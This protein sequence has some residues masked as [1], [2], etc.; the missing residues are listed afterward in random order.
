MISKFINSRLCFAALALVG[1][2]MQAQEVVEVDSTG[3]AASQQVID[4]VKTFEKFKV[5]GV[6]AQVGKYIVLDSDIDRKY[7]QIEQQGFSTADITRCELLGTLMEE[8][9]YAHHAIQDSVII[10]DA[11]VNATTDQ[12]IQYMLAQFNSEEQV[13]K[14]YK[15]KSMP[16]LRAELFQINKDNML[17]SE[18]QN[19][20]IEGVEITP[21]EVRTFFNSIPV[22]ERP[23]FSAEVEIAQIVIEPEIPQEE[24]QKVIDRLN[25]F[26]RGIVENGESFATKAVLYSQ[27]PG[28]STKGG[29]I[30]LKRSDNFVKEFK[31]V[32]FSLQEGEVSEPF[33]SEFGYH[34]LM[35]DKIRG[36][37]VDVRHI[38]LIPDVTDETVAVAKAKIENIRQRI[39]D[40][41][42]TFA[43]AA[44]SESDEKETKN[45][46]GQLVNP[47]S[48][49][50]RFDLTKM[51]P[52]LAQQIYN[53]KDKEVSQVLTDADRTGRKK[54]KIIMVTDR[55]DEHQADYSKDYE[56]IQDLALN[57]K[58]RR[59]IE[60][61]Q[62]EKILETFVSVNRDYY[63]C[64]F[65]SNWIKN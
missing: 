58:R 10:P 24:I 12:Q 57:D 1:L 27:D 11:Q 35:V 43:E 38:L 45:D 42:L 22:D 61:W 6:S 29:K 49:D 21:E 52:V 7:I 26:R 30:S 46:G 15:K 50:T 31:D 3:V 16:E 17:A 19:K 63:D 23:L 41:E 48:G 65:A 33:E 59:A 55:Y 34:I 5:D 64:D 14:F 60:E 2:Q 54:F 51:E 8:K 4:T 47:V 53:L 37:T 32:A 39:V 25:E 18:M 44:K 28:S 13:L 36:Q 20:I 9:L 62:D 56:K 40:G